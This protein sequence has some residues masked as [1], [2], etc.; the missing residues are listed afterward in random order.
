[1]T[2]IVVGKQAK[3][4]TNKRVANC[5]GTVNT[6]GSTLT[7]IEEDGSASEFEYDSALNAYIYYEAGVFQN[8]VINPLGEWI[9]RGERADLGR[10]YEIYDPIPMGGRLRGVGTLSSMGQSTERFRFDAAGRLSKALAANGDATNYHYSAA[11]TL[12]GAITISHN[13]VPLGM[14]QD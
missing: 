7:R 5:T 9:W 4:S 10:A 12:T 1:M 3:L 14:C 2:V 6:V 11:G 13:M 8:I